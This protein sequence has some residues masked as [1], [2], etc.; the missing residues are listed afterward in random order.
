QTEPQGDAAL[1]SWCGGGG[2]RPCDH[3][4]LS[5][6]NHS[7]ATISI[8][9]P[10]KEREL[11]HFHI[12]AGPDRG[13]LSPPAATAHSPGACPLPPAKTTSSSSDTANA[14]HAAAD[15]GV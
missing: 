1:L 4:T 3:V 6:T 13:F 2:G 8:T 12:L 15:P 10:I 11:E 9:Q 7:E 5:C 14:A